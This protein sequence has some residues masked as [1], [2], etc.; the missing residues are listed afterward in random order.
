MKRGLRI[1]AGMLS[2]HSFAKISLVLS[3]I[4]HD[5]ASHKVPFSVVERQKRVYQ[6]TRPRSAK[7]CHRWPSDGESRNWCQ[8]HLSENWKNSAWNGLSK[9]VIKMVLN[10][11]HWNFHSSNSMNRRPVIGDYNSLIML[12]SLTE[13]NMPCQFRGKITLKTQWIIT[14]WMSH[15]IPQVQIWW[16]GISVK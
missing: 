7:V 15:P 9:Q 3:L 4:L 6:V 5:S 2:R 13:S 11:F 16:M 10:S 14:L 8:R 12:T 1:N